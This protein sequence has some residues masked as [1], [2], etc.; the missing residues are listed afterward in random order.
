MSKGDL[1][2]SIRDI[3]PT[4]G[5]SETS[6]DVVP[7]REDMESLVESDKDAEKSDKAARGKNIALAAGVLIIIIIM[8][9]G[10]K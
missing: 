3:Y 10:A 8:L 9:G 2:F 4:A 7:D 6:T 5:N 1:V